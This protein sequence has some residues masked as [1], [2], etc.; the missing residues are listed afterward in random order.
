VLSRYEQKLSLTHMNQTVINS[1]CVILLTLC[2]GQRGT[3]VPSDFP[4]LQKLSVEELRLKTQ[5]HKKAWGFDKFDRWDLDQDTGELVFSFPDGIKAVSPAQII[6]TYNTRDHT[7]LWA[8]ANPSIDEK[9]SADALK[10]RKYGEE[11]KIDRLTKSKWAG[12]EE[13]AWAMAALAVKLCGKQGAY[14]GPAG[15]THVFIVFGEVTLSK[16]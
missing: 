9:L 13:D 12:I 11:H 4:T 3:K 15:A 8:W 6:G 7:W 1:C 5:A 2:I 16:K 14:R 10:V